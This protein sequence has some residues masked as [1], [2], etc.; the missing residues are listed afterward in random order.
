MGNRGWGIGKMEQK[1]RSAVSA[2]PFSIL[3]D[4]HFNQVY[5]Y[6]DVTE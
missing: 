6:E 4:G 2:A 3:E 1:R 5:F